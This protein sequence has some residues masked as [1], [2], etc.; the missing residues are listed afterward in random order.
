MH[1]FTIECWEVLQY[2]FTR[3][4]EPGY[5]H[6]IHDGSIFSEFSKPGRF[7]SYREHT[8]LI[9]NTDGVATFQ[10]TMHTLWPIYFTITSL[11]P[12]L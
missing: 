8:G 7:L 9:L 4:T 12:H 6:D 5:L 2:P 3:R 10:S 1:L 11:P